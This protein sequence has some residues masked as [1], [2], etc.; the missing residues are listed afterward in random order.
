MRN[1]APLGGG[2]ATGQSAA[3]GWD[4]RISDA[5]DDL[6]VVHPIERQP[7]EQQHHGAEDEGLIGIAEEFER[8]LAEVC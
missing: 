4:K 2:F 8:V 3:G 6:A 1:Q 5:K 7:I